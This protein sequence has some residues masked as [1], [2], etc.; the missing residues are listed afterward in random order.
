MRGPKEN[1]RILDNEGTVAR[2]GPK[3][4]SDEESSSIK[5]YTILLC[6]LFNNRRV[7]P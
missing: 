6:V 7:E 4:C 2:M 3:I 5:S 1:D